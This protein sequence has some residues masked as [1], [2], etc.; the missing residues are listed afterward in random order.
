MKDQ[1]GVLVRFNSFDVLESIVRDASGP[2]RTITIM[3]W[4]QPDEDGA[5]TPTMMI[6]YHDLRDQQPAWMLYLAG[7]AL[8]LAGAACFIA[9]RLSA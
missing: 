8:V 7:V 1:K 6:K 4:G 2:D 3:D 5:Y 9:G